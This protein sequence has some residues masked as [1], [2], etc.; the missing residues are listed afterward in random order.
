MAKN[1]KEKLFEEINSLYAEYVPLIGQ[2]NV[3]NKIQSI[4]EKIQI[5]VY[6][7][8]VKIPKT[9]EE[10]ENEADD[11]N[12]D[13]Y[14]DEI[15]SIS[16]KCFVS[17]IN[18]DSYGKMSFSQYACSSIKRRLNYLKE[19]K[20]IEQKNGGMKISDDAL[21]KAKKV[22]TLDEQYKKFGFKDEKVRNIKIADALEMNLEKI[23]E[24]KALFERRTVSQFQTNAEGETFDV[25]DKYQEENDVCDFHNGNFMVPPKVFERNEQ[26]EGLFS[27]IK[28]RLEEKFQK[29]SE[30]YKSFTKALTVDLLRKH[31]PQKKADKAGEDG[32]FVEARKTVDDDSEFIFNLEKQFRKAG[33]FDLK[34]IDHLFSDENYKL[35][36]MQSLAKEEGLEKSALTKRLARFYETVIERYED[37]GYE[38]DFAQKFLKE[39]A[40][41]K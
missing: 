35:P 40:S 1:E 31:F 32:Q 29:S 41:D 34:I 26:V 16:G 39:S 4:R 3:E 9:A 33:F 8:Y 6:E 17:F 18:S 25:I 30:E 38:V 13:S 15:F 2:T 12:Y 27:A 21:K 37:E 14:A 20:S 10:A 11:V 7:V 19:K 22:K 24:L 28:F 5:A 23:M 36:E